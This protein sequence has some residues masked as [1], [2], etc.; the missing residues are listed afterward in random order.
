MNS[1]YK[2]VDFIPQLVYG[3]DEADLSITTYYMRKYP[4]GLFDKTKIIR[5]GGFTLIELLVVIAIIAILAGMLLPA[6]SQA[7]EKGRLAVCMS[8]L[9]QINLALQTYILDNDGWFPPGWGPAGK[10]PLWWMEGSWISEF[11]GYD[12]DKIDSRGKRLN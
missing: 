7:R 1:F 2:L 10:P 12:Q 9:R 11:F 8:N 4:M 3:K 5:K 6:L